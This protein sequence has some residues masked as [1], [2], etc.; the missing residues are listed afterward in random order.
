[1]LRINLATTLT[2]GTKM[3]DAYP[4]YNY[5]EDGRY[6]RLDHVEPDAPWEVKMS[7]QTAVVTL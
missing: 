2:Y 5:N 1:M 7:R 3:K 4:G 6:V